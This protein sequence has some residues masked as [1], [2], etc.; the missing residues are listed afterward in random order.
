MQKCQGYDFTR[1]P[2]VH[3]SHEATH[4]VLSR[5]DFG[6]RVRLCEEHAVQCA[7]AWRNQGWGDS[8]VAALE[9]LA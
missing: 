6:A 7:S 2:A 4:T 1:D 3:C 5:Y 8:E 9:A